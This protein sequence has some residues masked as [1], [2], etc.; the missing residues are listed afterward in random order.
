MFALVKAVI[1]FVFIWLVSMGR[2][3]VVPITMLASSIFLLRI[4]SFLDELTQV[5]TSIARHSWKAYG[6]TV[7][8]VLAMLLLSLLLTLHVT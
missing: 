6:R 5:L 2:S 8:V 1:Q 3:V 4:L 7:L